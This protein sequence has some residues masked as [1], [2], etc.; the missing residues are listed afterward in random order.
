MTDKMNEN[1]SASWYA[2]NTKNKIPEIIVFKKHYNY[3]VTSGSKAK[4]GQVRHSSA[5][6]SFS[7]FIIA[8]RN[9][10]EKFRKK[11]SGNVIIYQYCYCIIIMFFKYNYF[12]CLI[13]SIICIPRSTKVFIHFVSHILAHCNVSSVYLNFSGMCRKA[14][15]NPENDRKAEIYRTWP[16]FAFCHL[17]VHCQQNLR[18]ISQYGGVDGRKI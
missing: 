18:I 5:F 8:L 14:M 2:N 10:P 17:G 11:S 3:T 7:G 9:I 4:V 16:T 12:L 1:F 6:R 15:I 13:F